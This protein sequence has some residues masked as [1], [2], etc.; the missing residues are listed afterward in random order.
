MSEWIEHDG[1]ARPNLPP[2]TKVRIRTRAG[3]TDEKFKHAP[4]AWEW[5]DSDEDEDSSWVGTGEFSICAYRVVE[6]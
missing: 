6:E 5:W 2:G 1:I 4:W 3:W